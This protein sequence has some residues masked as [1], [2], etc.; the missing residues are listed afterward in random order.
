MKK[1]FL[2]AWLLCMMLFITASYAL[3]APL[4]ETD[5]EA[6]IAQGV[7]L[8]RIDRF[9][10]NTW[11][12]IRVLYVDLTNDNLSLRV[13]TADGGV[14]QRETTLSMA[15]RAGAIAAVNGDF[16][17][18]TAP[19]TNMLGMV[20]QK[21]ELH[22]SPSADA[23]L[24][25]LAF[26]EN[27]SVLMDYFSFSGKVTAP[28]GYN[29]PLFAINK[30]P[31]TTGGITM[32]TPAWGEKTTGIL[33]QI[34]MTELVV[35]DGIVTDIR[36]GMEPA[37]IPENGYVL[38]TNGAIN[39]FLQEA[40][41]V[42]DAVEL[43]TELAPEIDQIREATGGG[44]LLVQNGKIS[45]FTHN[46]SGY[47][48]RTAIGIDKNGTTLMLVTVDGRLAECEGMTQTELARV[49]IELGCDT[50]INLDGGGSTTMVARD[51]FSGKLAVQNTLTGSMR[52]V[53]TA[54]GIFE[55][56]PKNTTASGIAVRTS[57]SEVYPGEPVNIEYAVYNKYGNNIDVSS[58]KV[59][60]KTDR[61]S[62]I[63]GTQIVPL[64]GGTYTVTVTCG[65]AKQTVHFESV[66]ELTDIYLSSQSRRISV[67]SSYTFTLRGTD[68]YG[69]SVSVPASKVKW[70]VDSDAF[71]VQNGK[72]TAKAAGSAFLCAELDGMRAYAAIATDGEILYNKPVDVGVPH[73]SYG[74][75]NGYELYISG[76]GYESN[77]LLYRLLN[78][79]RNG[80]L[81]SKKHAYRL[82]AYTGET[83]NITA[84]TGF[85]K[86]S[87]NNNLLLTVNNARGGIKNTDAAQWPL[88]ISAVLNATE[89]SIVIIM[90]KTVYGLEENEKGVLDALLADAV[91]RGKAV[92]L[93]Y[94]GSET[95]YA[96]EKGVTYLVC[97]AMKNA[98]TKTF[99]TDQE[100][101]A[102]IRLTLTLNGVCFS[103]VQ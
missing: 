55:A 84:I 42:G 103:Y 9:Y 49:L 72:V 5:T 82:G 73:P 62:K 27:G 87:I 4:W 96:M 71:I 35:E 59:S 2:T 26:L 74:E 54:I 58:S 99:F 22:S 7:T 17:N 51:R 75:G 47:A 34:P 11:D 102:C 90:P 43:E 24:A 56:A 10:Q 92:Y 31:V 79:Q 101:F 60:I 76:N 30:V 88:L 18:M 45:T 28:A 57:K 53:S 8:R 65:N 98:H 33:K 93:V 32:L 41:Q 70:S 15:E 85:T 50:A 66:E 21:G 46:I 89:K 44:T 25:N 38:V 3:A 48:Q 77:N 81:A 40:F 94:E 12:R 14:S 83:E 69:N 67:G 39:G 52:S 23:G 68:E 91:N 13:L 63:T 95:D 64:E 1:A 20:V 86:Q 37:P 16:F 80:F 61:A 97:G 29:C 100:R 36:I 6:Q 78:A 19:P